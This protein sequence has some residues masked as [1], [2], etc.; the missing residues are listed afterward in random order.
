MRR[1]ALRGLFARKLRLAL[2]ALAVALGVTLIAGTYVFTDTINGSFD[3]IFTETN[4]GTDVALVPQNDLSGD[5]DPPPI[6][7]SVLDRVKA[8]DG[9]G[10]VEGSIFSS[11]VSFRKADGSKLGGQGGFGAIASSSND[12]RFQDFST[13]DGRMPTGP[14]EVAIDK[15]LA[16]KGD[17]KVGSKIQ[18]SAQAPKKAYTVTG[19]VQIAGVDSLGGFSIAVMTLPEAQR[20]TDKTAAFDE[21]DVGAAAGTT[22]EQ[23]LER[24]KP[25][26]PR[27]VEVRTGEQQAE[28]QSKDIRDNLG[29]LRTALLAFAGISLFVGAFIIFNTFSITVQQRTR[30]FGLLRTLGAKRRQ[31]LQ[32]VLGEGIV[33]GVLG[34]IVGLGLGVLVAAGL[35]ALFKAVGFDV[36][37][38]GSVIA[39]RTVVVSLLVGTLV[40][41]VATLSPALRAT[42]VP[43]IAALQEG[44]QREARHSRFATPLAALLTV[45]G[46]VL[47]ALGLFGS[48]DANAALSAVGFGALATFLG[49]ALLSPRLVGPIASAVGRPMEAV[50]GITGRLA[51]ENSVR[52]PG[53]TAVTAGALM[54]GVALVT[55]A[56]VFAAG[57]KTTIDKAID[58][59]S[60]AQAVV[61]NANGWG[62]FS[63]QATKEV[64]QVAGV[65]RVAAV[66]FGESRY[67]GEDKGVTGVDPQTFSSLY[68]SG[69]DEGSDATMRSLGDGEVIV[70]QGFAEDK[71]LKVGQ[72][73]TVETGLAKK[74]PLKIIGILDDKGGLTSAMTVTNDVLAKD[75]GFRK[76]GFVLVGFDG[77]RPEKTVLADMTKVLDDRFPEA[78]ALTNQEFK[79]QQA[80]QINQTLGLI[81]ALLALAIIVSLFGIV[82]TLV[83]SISE[84]TRELGMLRAIGMSRRQVRRVIRYE[85]VIVATIG[86]VIG[87]VVGVVLSVL[88]TQAIDGSSLSIPVASL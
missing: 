2:T 12:K 60:R 66:R 59:G 40:T 78:E 45:A 19:L 22:P 67:D 63:P 43:P 15:G 8:V 51:R 76:D 31:V 55:F 52:Q 13:V 47:M 88:V 53:R 14:G 79:D 35:K 18:I 84:R 10:V 24:I 82:N 56:S 33:L 46:L 20:V 86:G 6:P 17:F 65:D 61:Q 23:L 37:A 81:Y 49:V 54:V 85:A 77:S 44:W 62:S 75:F 11:G 28:A 9:V 70:Q 69:W 71:G 41:L 80:G 74:V 73:I 64:S 32:S 68:H 30:E 27:N 57:A 48:M 5:E 36:P 72:T 26:V 4:K 38:N 83:L 16:E 42:R 87:L 21:I 50:R 58:N 3:R 7:A 29:F 25:I 1:V 34:S 39:T